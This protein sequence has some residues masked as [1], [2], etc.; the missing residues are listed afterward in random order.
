M[1]HGNS[2]VQ[3]VGLKDT[4]EYKTS[5]GRTRLRVDMLRSDTSDA[6]YLLVEPGILFQPG[7]IP[8]GYGTV[9]VRPP[10][11]PDVARYFVEGRY[12]G[13]LEKKAT[14]N[15]GASW[16]RNDDAG[17]LNRY[18]LFGGLGRAWRDRE[19]L[20]FRTNYALSYTDR[21]EDVVDPLKDRRFP[22]ARLTADFMDKW[23]KVTTYDND[24]TFNL[25]LFDLSDYTADLVQS[26]SVSMSK[27]LSL[28][29]SLQWAYSS[30][31]ALEEVDVIL[32]AR[33]VNPDGIPG[34]GDEFYETVS[35]GGFEI[36]INQ[37]VLRKQK[38]DTTIR[39]SL[40]IS[41]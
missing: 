14:W 41:F 28:K 24:F 9:A 5:Q 15:T 37:D 8:S 1:T 40:Q 17:I 18:V 33:L 26:V 19:D 7:E 2:S 10:S 25:S 12:E 29:V 30:E 39:T 16:D 3:T 32:R 31:P 35:S 20:R 11:E 27:R 22:G 36:T 6:P 23:G 13:N 38:L 21:E 4:L 34:N